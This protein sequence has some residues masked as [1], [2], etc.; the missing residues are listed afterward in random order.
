[1][2]IE[3][4]AEDFMVAATKGAVRQLVAIKN[5]RMGHDHGG[6]SYRKMTQ[7]LADSI[8]GELG[9]IAVSKFTGL[10]QSSTLQITK[11][12]D[13]GASIEVRT[14]EHANGH[15]VLYDSSNNDYI[16]VFVT[17]SGLKATLRGWINPEHGKKAEYFV[18]G[19]PDC[20]FV[21]QS[22]LN[23]IETLPIK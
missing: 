20:Y 10:T 3:L 2:I 4:T 7:R 9:E 13:I 14:T 21:P 12:A 15:L 6:K 8:L 22:A 18:E 17:I 11:A 16:F 23:P 5:K 1:M 19:D